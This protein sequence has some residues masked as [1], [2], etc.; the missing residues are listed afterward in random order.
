MSS[1]KFPNAISSFAISV[2][3]IC[4][5]VTSAKSSTSAF[6]IHGGKEQKQKP[7]DCSRAHQV[8]AL[9]A[10]FLQS[11]ANPSLSKIL[12]AT[13]PRQEGCI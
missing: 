9:L 13:C 6:E 10:S 8:W 2:P 3:A 4:P 1:Q 5:H 12:W 7:R 11:Q